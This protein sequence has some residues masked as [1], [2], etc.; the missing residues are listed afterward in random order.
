MVFISTGRILESQPLLEAFGNAKTTL[1]DNSS[2]FG[3]YIVVQFN[4]GGTVVGAEIHRYLLE[5]SRLVSHNE[6]EVSARLRVPL[7]RLRLPTAFPPP[8]SREKCGEALS[9]QRVYERLWHSLHFIY[10]YINTFFLKC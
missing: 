5:K 4:R 2:R 10:Y 9:I 7:I 1:N 3:K 8:F 6:G